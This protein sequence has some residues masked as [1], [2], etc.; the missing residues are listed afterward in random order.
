MIDN[1]NTQV[2]V[3][4]LI[5]KEFVAKKSED[6]DI[7]VEIWRKL[8]GTEIHS[9]P[10]PR[11]LV[12]GHCQAAFQTFLDFVVS[13]KSDFEILAGFYGIYLLYRTQNL[14][15][16][17]KIFIT[18]DEFFKISEKAKKIEKLKP[19]F[20][21]LVNNE[22]F[23]FTGE[24]HIIPTD[25]TSVP[26]KQVPVDRPQ[27]SQIM[28]TKKEKHARQNTVASTTPSYEELEEEY[29]GLMEEILK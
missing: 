16:P 9:L 24:S 2:Y 14:P 25:N 5:V 3:A 22:A 12:F 26:P 6:F 20:V 17:E 8:K 27:F 10:S 21:F 18:S 19:I 1:T 4:Q 7:F 11:Q 15:E 23:C 28:E 13:K 29:K